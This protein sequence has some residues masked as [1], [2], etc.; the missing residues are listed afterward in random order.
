MITGQELVAKVL[1]VEEHGWKCANVRSLE[2]QQT[3][4]GF[5][6]ALA[7][8]VFINSKDDKPGHL[9]R[10]AVAMVVKELPE[11]F[12]KEYLSSVSGIVFARAGT[13]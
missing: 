11:E 9:Q 13:V 5:S 1:E 6:M 12:V 7:P 2:Q 3:P 4:T 10:T 8:Y